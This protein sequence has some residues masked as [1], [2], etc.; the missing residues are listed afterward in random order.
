MARAKAHALH[1]LVKSERIALDVLHKIEKGANFSDM[2]K[3]FSTCPSAKKGGDLGEF[4]KGDMV[5]SFDQ[6]VFN[7]ELY[8]VLGP[9]KTQFGYHLIKVIDRSN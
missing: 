9:V 4:N 1:I 6:A 2:A 5:K 8:K 3:R 7:G